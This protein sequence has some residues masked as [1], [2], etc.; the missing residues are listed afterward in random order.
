MHPLLWKTSKNPQDLAAITAQGITPESAQAL[1]RHPQLAIA[2]VDAEF[3][4]DSFTIS[5]FNPSLAPTKLAN[6]LF[7]KNLIDPLPTPLTAQQIIP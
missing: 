2:S 7:L 6:Q 3:K 5:C 1:R 4:P